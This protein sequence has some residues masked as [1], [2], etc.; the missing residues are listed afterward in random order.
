MYLAGLKGLQGVTNHPVHVMGQS[1]NFSP[2][3]LI[4]LCNFG[5]S[6]SVMGVKIDKFDVPFC[7]SFRPKIIQDQLCYSVDPNNYKE[8]IDLK[9]D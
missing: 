7:N 6:M 3:A 9:G 2:T 1:G 8:K 5:G 4:P